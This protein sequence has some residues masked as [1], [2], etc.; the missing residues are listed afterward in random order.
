MAQVV[1]LCHASQGSG[2][3]SWAPGFNLAYPG[4]CGH[5]GSE[6]EDWSS[7]KIELAYGNTQ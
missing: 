6:A 2:L 3:S 7:R 4:Y 5:S 1:G